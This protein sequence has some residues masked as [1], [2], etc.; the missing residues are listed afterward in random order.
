MISTSFACQEVLGLY[1]ELHSY[2]IL[3]F[4]SFLRTHW[5]IKGSLLRTLGTLSDKEA[6]WCRVLHSTFKSFLGGKT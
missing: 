2:K 1:H 4:Q 6:I 3:F 5:R